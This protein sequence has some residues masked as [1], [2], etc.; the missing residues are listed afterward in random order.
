I[1]NLLYLFSYV[2][3]GALNIKR[4][5]VFNIL[6]L[7]MSM[8]IMNESVIWTAGFVNYTLPFV[9]V[10]P[11]V[12][13]DQL[14]KK[15]NYSPR[16][17]TSF[18]L[19]SLI[20][21][22]L[23]GF[24]LENLSTTVIFYLFTELII[25][26][27]F[28]RKD[29][30]YRI[31][32]LLVSIVSFGIMVVHSDRFTSNA[33]GGYNR[34]TFKTLSE[35]VQNIKAVQEIIKN[36]VFKNNMYMILLVVILFILFA[37]LVLSRLQTKK[38]KWLYG[39]VIFQATLIFLCPTYQLVI[40][41]PNLI[42]N[43]MFFPSIMILILIGVIMYGLVEDKLK[44]TLPASI[45]VSSLLIVSAIF[46]ML[47]FV[48]MAKWNANLN[49]ANEAAISQRTAIEYTKMKPKYHK[50]YYCDAQGPMIGANWTIVYME[51]YGIPKD[52]PIR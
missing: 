37:G 6:F 40:L 33:A 34:T 52:V 47:V 42:S 16:L 18:K 51:Y 14:L 30:L 44:H 24:F 9:F 21:I 38:D 27:I 2:F 13:I 36:F 5:A 11:V 8:T 48:D 26:A 45:I 50:Y 20:C 31:S 3:R 35:L 29:W 46:P 4:I 32:A 25:N 22:F 39:L 19:V 43:R 10:L 15:Q 7:L 17:L 41:T 28:Y 49:R 12:Y 1:F 23:S